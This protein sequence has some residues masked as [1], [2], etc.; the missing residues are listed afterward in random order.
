VSKPVV[1]IV[2]REDGNAC[3]PATEMDSCWS[4]EEQA[5]A[6]VD[7]LHSMNMSAHVEPMQPDAGPV[8]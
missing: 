3:C 7:I 6:R 8:R 1:F 5:N 4:S 2:M